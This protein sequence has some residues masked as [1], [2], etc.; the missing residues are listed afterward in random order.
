MILERLELE[1]VRRFCPRFVCTFAPGLNAVLG[2]NES[3]KS[4]IFKALKA[5]LFF[6]PKSTREEVRSLYAWTEDRPFAIRLNFED[7]DSPYSLWKDFERKEILLEEGPTGRVWTD[8]KSAQNHLYKLLGLNSVELF[9]ASAAVAQGRLVLPER[10]KGR[11]ALDEALAEVMTGGGDTGGAARATELLSKDIQS[12]TVGLKDKAYKTPGP[13]KSAEERLGSL[14]GRRHKAAAKCA[15]RASSLQALNSAESQ[16]KEVAEALELKRDLMKVESERREIEGALGEQKKRYEEIDRR[17][18]VLEENAKRLKV[19]EQK[20]GGLGLATELEDEDILALR[21]ALVRRESLTSPLQEARR[22][23]EDTSIPKPWAAIALGAMGITGPLV[24][25]L[26]SSW[27][28]LKVASAT[29]GFLALVAAAWLWY[30]Q[31]ARLKVLAEKK[32]EARRS[33]ADLE[34]I[35]SRVRELV[36]R[37]GGGEPEGVFLKVAE[38]DRCREEMNKLSSERNGLLAGRLAEDLEAERTEVVRRMAVSEE[39]LSEECFLGPALDAEGFQA[40]R[41]EV[42]SLQERRDDLTKQ[43]ERLKG[44]LEASADGS[45]E[46][47]ELEEAIEDAE[48]ELSRYRQRLRVRQLAKQALEEAKREVLEPVRER[49]QE[50]LGRNMGSISR[51]RYGAVE[52]GRSWVDIEVL[53]PEREDSVEPKELSF[54]TAEQLLLAARLAFTDILAGPKKPP[55]LLDEPFGAFDEERLRATMGLLGSIAKE[56]QVILFTHQ[57]FVA[58]ACDHVVALPHPGR[59]P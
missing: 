3:G 13:I 19:L 35:D 44:V 45:E 57:E 17:L 20:L 43:I 8:V 2:P 41:R 58:T 53:G 4:T 30:R 52:L 50:T 23:V 26:A 7:G 34:E 24:V 27:E 32:V 15:Q 5:A 42:E 6:D 14:F 54:G 9:A 55:L 25:G 10:G 18:R 16:L 11:K 21:A 12:L 40:L 47:A 51:G 1:R 29:L 37:A 39:R 22:S 36:E 33:E 56:R 31:K 59:G 49:F 48:R 46:L 38:A 28:A